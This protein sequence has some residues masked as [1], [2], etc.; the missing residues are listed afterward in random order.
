MKY[1][2]PA[3]ILY[4]LLSSSFANA[5]NIDCF[6]AK[7]GGKYLIQEGK[8]CNIRYSP[9]STFKIALAAIGYDS[10]ILKDA[11]RPIL[12]PQKPVTFLSDYWSGEKTPS[13]WM[14]YSVVWYSQS[15]T[16]KLGMDKF[17]NYVDKLNYGNKDLSGNIGLNDGL[18]QSWLSSSLLISPSEQISFIEKLAKNELPLSVEAQIKTKNI[19]RLFEESMLS[20]GWTI[21]G[22][23]GTDV[24][25][26]TGERKGYFA[27][28]ATK[29]GRL[30][31]FVIH[32]SGA[33][34][35]KISGIYAKKT[36]MDIMMKEIFN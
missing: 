27:G 31:S 16:E 30:V 33:K 34:N 22:K 12:K 10:G 5:Q 9:A 15:I 2:I 13:D 25:R 23:T 21:Y 36:A 32:I 11:N 1:L 3:S 24:D 19:L 6:I 4:L 26:K 28:F 20:N 18:T 17:Q 8:N 14:K 29:D 35:S 7:E